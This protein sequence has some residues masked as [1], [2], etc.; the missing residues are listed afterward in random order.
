MLFPILWWN[1]SSKILFLPMSSMVYTVYCIC[2][3]KRDIVVKPVLYISEWS[4]AQQTNSL[5]IYLALACPNVPGLQTEEGCSP[6]QPG[7]LAELSVGG[8]PLLQ[9]SRL[10]G[11]PGRQWT[12][13]GRRGETGDQPGGSQPT[14][15]LPVSLS[16]PDW[17]ERGLQYGY[18][19]HPARQSLPRYFLSNPKKAN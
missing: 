3:E 13:A 16:L 15:E 10:S 4:E 5:T 18:P 11:Q 7:P 6:P 19:A 14:L 17:S 8:Q 1:K 12:A 2:R 9:S